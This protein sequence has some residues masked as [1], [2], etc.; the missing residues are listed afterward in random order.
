MKPQAGIITAVVA[1][2]LTSAL[3]GSRVQ[4]GGP[5]CAFVALL[6]PIVAVHG[7]DG[8]VVCTLLSGLMLIA[9]GLAGSAP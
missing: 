4:I 7:P 5:A 3:G 2:F 6:A 8:L 9:M 1:A